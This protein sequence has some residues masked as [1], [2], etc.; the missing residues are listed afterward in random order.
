MLSIIICGFILLENSSTTFLNVYKKTSF[1]SDDADLI[2]EQQLS[3]LLSHR[4]III[5][6]HFR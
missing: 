5:L 1:L 6:S 4:A 3:Y 2:V